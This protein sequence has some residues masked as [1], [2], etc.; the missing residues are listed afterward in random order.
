[1]QSEKKREGAAMRKVWLGMAF[2]ATL[3]RVAAFAADPPAGDPSAKEPQLVR[4]VLPL[5]K[6]HCVKCHG[7]AKQEAKLNLST[8]GG[9]VRGGETGAA[10]LPG[11]VAE[12]LLWQ[13]VEG[14]EMPPDDPLPDAEKLI[15]KRWIAA[16]ALGL[17]KARPVGA[18]DHW[19]FDLAAEPAVPALRDAAAA[20][21]AVDRFIIAQLEP[22]GL[23]LNPEADRATL[24]RRVS[25][26]LTGL[27][28]TPREVRAFVADTSSDAYERM[29]E[30][31]LAS[32]HYGQRWGK[33]WL[34]AAGYADS[35]GYFNADTDRPLAYRYRDYVVRSLNADKPLDRFVVEQL[36]GD[37]LAGF[38]PGHATTPEAI[39]LLEATHFVR[40]G[41]DGTGESDGNAEEVR[42]DRYSALEAAT[43]IVGSSL[44]GLTVQCAK[45]HDHKFEP[46]SQRDYYQLQ[47]VFYPAFN[48]REWLKPNDRVV[49]ANLPGDLERWEANGKKIDA[50]IVALKAEFAAWAHA[51]RP[52]STVLFHDEFDETGPPLA[53]NWTNIAPGDDAPGGT[54]PVA[55]DSRQAPAAARRAGVLEILES[56]ADGDR[57]LSTKAAFDWTPEGDGQWIQVSFDL[58]D[59]KVA[60]GRGPAER[61]A[62]F[63]ALHDFD[64]SGS[65]AGGNVLV[66]GN[67]AGGAEVHVDYPGADAKGA[68]QLGAA[69]YEPGHNYGVRVTNIGGGKFRLDHLVDWAWDEK[70]I[71]LAADDLPD[72][73]FGFEF[74]CGRSFVVDNVVVERGLDDAALDEPGKQA[75]ERFQ[76]RQKELTAAVEAKGRERGDKPGRISW[77]TDRSEKPPEVF[78][79]AR[80][81]YATPGEAV[82]PAPL[83]ALSEPGATLDIKPPSADSK[84]TGRRLAWV[85]WLTEPDSRQA[86]LLARVQAN[87]IWQHHFGVGLV[88]TSDNLGASGSPPSHPELLDYLASQMIR[89]GWSMKAMHRL[90][91][92]SAAYRQ[93]SRLAPKAFAIDPENRLL[94]RYSVRRLD[95]ESL[96]D[97]MLAVAGQLDTRMNGPYVPTTRNELGE[98]LGKAD[99]PAANRRSLYLQQRRTQTL[100]L[101][102][103][104]DSPS[105][106]FNC[107]QRPTSTMPLQSL[108][109]LN[110]DF[111][112]RQAAAFA[113][114]TLHE[115]GAEPAARVAHAHLLAV[116][117]EPT[118]DETRTSLEFVDAMRRHYAGSADGETRA[119]SDFCQML[120]A[121]SEFL[122]V[123]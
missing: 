87:R 83:S 105:L 64:D 110:S 29:V 102:N 57:W 71:K 23:T 41:P 49:V 12:S 24:V 20:R 44:L 76:A 1:V 54:P 19:A 50:E 11:Q 73:G 99:G 113:V 72:G 81:N 28:P 52:P 111:V 5:F 118:S 74:C 95:A 117:R 94:W 103:V 123:E 89:S 13:R 4:D 82:Q 98:V 58:I 120:L 60:G 10:I 30:R 25:F 100:S 101:L 37:E 97:A 32:P 15:L 55:L 68:G 43:Q 108:S 114:R 18:A 88:A 36:A 61:I 119:W 115:A 67:P 122:Y 2:F 96:R 85:R 116:G 90:L 66:D 92:T 26:D 84:S 33:Y 7:P 65:V 121:S 22:L 46:I 9:L 16:G 77:V 35:N 48:V 78:L 93:T 34:D 91:V 27:P 56:G 3:C 62:Y 70:S 17:P 80:G 79:L 107:V 40:N 112:V 104:F 109:L 51:N 75:A 59:N 47:A 21:T 86:A 69:R 63:I 6:T 45:C 8:A 106:V 39:S 53:D 31:Y 38:V 42:V 14:D